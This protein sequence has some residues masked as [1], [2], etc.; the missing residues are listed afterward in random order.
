[1]N[2]FV[3]NFFD[4]LRDD[5]VPLLQV[6]LESPRQ[7]GTPSSGAAS[8]AGELTSPSVVTSTTSDS[9]N[10]SPL[11]FPALG[12][13]LTKVSVCFNS[14]CKFDRISSH[15]I[16]FLQKRIT[17]S[18]IPAQ[19]SSTFS[20]AVSIPRVVS[21]SLN[22]V[23]TG[24][25]SLSVA[26]SAPSGTTLSG[27]KSPP[28]PAPRAS[29]GFMTITKGK[30]RKNPASKQRVVPTLLTNTSSTPAG[31]PNLPPIAVAA[32]A[33][34]QPLC[35]AQLIEAPQIS[36][37]D[38]SEVFL[39]SLQG[40]HSVDRAAKLFCVA[41][42]NF[43]ASRPVFQEL[44]FLLELLAVPLAAENPCALLLRTGGDAVSFSISCVSG[45][46]QYLGCFS[47]QL[48][49]LLS[50]NA[51]IQSVFPAFSREA[52][53]QATLRQQS[54]RLSVSSMADSHKTYTNANW[55]PG[56]T[57]RP[58]AKDETDLKNN[59]E[60]VLDAFLNLI[61]ECRSSFD[62]V[63]PIYHRGLPLWSSLNPANY[64]WFSNVF[65]T[66][67]TNSC[68][69]EAHLFSAVLESRPLQHVEKPRVPYQRMQQLDQRLGSD[70]PASV[71]IRA[72]ENPL[73]Q[74]FRGP[75][76]VF[77]N[78]ISIAN[79][80]MLSQFLLQS[81]LDKMLS[82]LLTASSSLELG[83]SEQL[84][85]LKL[86]AKFVAF[87]LRLGSALSVPRR[88]HRD[89]PVFVNLVAALN[90]TDPARSFLN[91]LSALEFASDRRILTLYIP[92]IVEFAHVERLDPVFRQSRH[93]RELELSLSAIFED[94][95]RKMQKTTS[96][97]FVQSLLEAYFMGQPLQDSAAS[98][99]GLAAQ[100]NTKGIWEELLGAPEK[101]PT[102]L[103]GADIDEH[104]LDNHSPFI[105]SYKSSM[106]K[107][108]ASL[109]ILPMP[110]LTSFP[111]KAAKSPVRVLT[112]ASLPLL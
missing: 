63:Q 102:D 18:A 75:E 86:L 77:A 5:A 74:A 26:P 76:I 36:T 41:A 48:L 69:V 72:S 23:W 3:Q 31:P 94:L 96:Q 30:I 15:A 60:K 34:S 28:Q 39:S 110:S 14:V 29:A 101:S 12:Q 16:H 93:H 22:S 42:S 65:V 91:L 38:S 106:Q 4:L 89:H 55:P 32:P 87:I 13:A 99:D 109:G 50:Q 56:N 95:R 70:L 64:Q 82:L 46:P 79:D 19:P 17:P 1:M 43:P 98:Q 90:R 80:Q 57:A 53:A 97:F 104:L 92:W 111:W 40:R 81:L 35:V 27:D 88:M 24:N 9:K 59:R 47:E 33:A 37:S 52:A 73:L 8:T 105:A 103:D 25:R 44:Q 51:A 58:R 107:A 21:P 83:L 85:H 54:R 2:N 11:E 67:L 78:I 49:A 20:S 84:S 108:N 7:V 62:S 66:E 112:A 71:L 45:L 68:F 61:Q 100:R 10:S 6:K